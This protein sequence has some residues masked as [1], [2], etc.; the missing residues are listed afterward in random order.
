[1]K[2]EIVGIWD[3]NYSKVV[4][5]LCCK[6]KEIRIR[7][8]GKKL[9]LKDK[10]REFY[11]CIVIGECIEIPIYGPSKEITENVGIWNG[12]FDFFYHLLIRKNPLLVIQ[13]QG[14]KLSIRDT[15]IDFYA[16][17][18]FGSTVEIPVYKEDDDEPI[19]LEDP[20]T[21]KQTALSEQQEKMMREWG[22]I[23]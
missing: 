12:D 5:I 6:Y 1:M 8:I 21:P 2:T 7:T 23:P 3:G 19:M 10:S 22:L 9:V 4:S 13:T 16:C 20:L 18:P 15:E 11:S 14:K 17:V